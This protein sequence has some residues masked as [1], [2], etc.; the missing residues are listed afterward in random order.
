MRIKKSAGGG[1][2]GMRAEATDPLVIPTVVGNK[3]AQSNAKTLI[4]CT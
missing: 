2:L 3:T 4:S 1:A